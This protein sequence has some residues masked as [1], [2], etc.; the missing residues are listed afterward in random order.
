MSAYSK[1]HKMFLS[2][3]QPRPPN[4]WAPGDL[5]LHTELS[6]RSDI[7]T[8]HLLCFIISHDLLSVSNIWSI[9][10]E[11]LMILQDDFT[12]EHLLGLQNIV[13]INLSAFKL[14]Y[15]RRLITRA[16][17]KQLYKKL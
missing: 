6:S 8:S 17:L 9:G 13:G 3:L 7:R 11:A 4:N 1:S 10:P 16:S 12:E 15:F 2:T 5:Q 14:L